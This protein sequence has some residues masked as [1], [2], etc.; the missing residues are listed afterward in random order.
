[1]PLGW[2]AMFLVATRRYGHSRL[3]PQRLVRCR[4]SCD[5]WGPEGPCSVGVAEA[6]RW[7]KAACLNPLLNLVGIPELRY[8][9][10]VPSWM[11]RVVDC[12][13]TEYT[14]IGLSPWSVDQDPT[15]TS[16][17]TGGVI[18]VCSW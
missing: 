10:N 6:F 14:E 4:G 7:C 3:E 5:S 8:M 17:L 15:I 9:L 13:A 1:M 12:G 16:S 11:L 2:L 18:E